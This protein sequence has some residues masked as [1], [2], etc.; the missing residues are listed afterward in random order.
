LR[1]VAQVFANVLT[2]KRSEEECVDLLL[3]ETAR[4]RSS[5]SPQ[6]FTI[7]APRLFRILALRFV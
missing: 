4:A 1:L 7:A 5:S 6:G 2:R 3:G